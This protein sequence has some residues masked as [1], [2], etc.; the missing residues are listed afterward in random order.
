M[1]NELL[2]TAPELLIGVESLDQIGRGTP[3]ADIYSFAVIMYEVLTRE[4]PFYDFEMGAKELLDIIGHRKIPLVSVTS[5]PVAVRSALSVAHCSLHS[6]GSHRCRLDPAS[7]HGQTQHSRMPLC[8]PEFPRMP[9]RPMKKCVA[10]V[11]C[12]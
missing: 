3:K 2:W 8:A 9:L 1:A 6:C 5:K 11:T 4:Q 12:L 10:F 7:P